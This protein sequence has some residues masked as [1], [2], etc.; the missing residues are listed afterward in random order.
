MLSAGKLRHRIQIQY[1]YETQ[2]QD[3]GA[4]N[5]V[6]LTLATV[7]AAI[8]PVSAREFIAS[9]SETSRITTRITI[10]YRND[11]SEKMRLYHSSKNMYYD[12][13]GLL[14]DKDS[15]L[16]YLTLPCSE[17]VKY[18]GG[19]IAIPVNLTLPEIYVLS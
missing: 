4:I 1:P 15:G 7:W 10:R 2:D 16:E 18:E 19:I 8:E 11:I 9:Q 12:I 14:S 13:H 3:T 6:W 17:G 5:V